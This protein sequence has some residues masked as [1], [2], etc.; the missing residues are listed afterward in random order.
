M[1]KGFKIYFFLLL[2]FIPL[3]V[4]PQATQFI[5]ESFQL[6]INDLEANRSPVYDA[7]DNKCALIKV[8]TD[9]T[10]LTFSSNNGIVEQKKV[11]TEYWIYVSFDEKRLNIYKDGFLPLNY[12]IP[13][14]MEESKVYTFYITTSKRYSIVIQTEPKDAIVKIDNKK[15]TTPNVS[16]VNPGSHIIKIETIGY[17]P[18][19]DTIKVGEGSIYFN[20]TLDKLEPV[21]A[22]FNSIPSGATII[23]NNEYKGQTPKQLFLYPGK[24]QL[25]LDKEFYTVIKKEITIYKDSSNDFNYELQLNTAYLGIY[26]FPGNAEVFLDGNKIIEKTK[27]EGG[28]HI[29]EVKL[30][31]Y[32]T[33]K[34]VVNIR[35]GAD[36]VLTISLRPIVGN[37]QFTVNPVDADVELY[38]EDELYSE[39]TG[40]KRI[41][42]IQIG[43]Y[44]AVVDAKRY[45]KIE[46]EI[47]IKENTTEDIYVD[48]TRGKQIETQ[49]PDADNQ[50]TNKGKLPSIALSI[51]FPGLGQFYS[52]HTT[53]ALIYSISGLGAAGATYYFNSEF[54]K[55]L[56]KYNTSK[57]AYSSSTTIEEI[58]IARKDMFDDYDAL[59]KINEYRKIVAI[60]FATIY[61]ISLFDAIFFGGK[62][63]Q[64]VIGKK[65][66]NN[67]KLHIQPDPLYGGIGLKMKYSF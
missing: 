31:K 44:K 65:I 12:D 23:I 15:V 35:G 63:E 51:A 62:K 50:A 16:N 53:R 67:I 5:V 54:T 43:N 19:E 42:K 26:T 27:I 25:N 49:K 2:L 14:S 20:Y 13:V 8:R 32:Y 29:V 18:V 66:N 7:N 30:D 58:S 24:N 36:T 22:T 45:R 47:N 48:L 52:G 40:A 61:G 1:A 21:L 4:T 28:E 56:N 3:I 37:L 60:S 34:K 39:W 10:D 59:N 41:E 6:D 11:L 64:I 17:M 55:K 46:Q 57:K 33:E 9:L 38:K